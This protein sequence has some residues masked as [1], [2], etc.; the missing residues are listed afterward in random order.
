MRLIFC[1]GSTTRQLQIERLKVR[2]CGLVSRNCLPVEHRTR[3]EVV[4]TAE[5]RP[6]ARGRSRR[7][8][9]TG[10]TEL[11][12]VSQKR[13]R[14]RA[15]ASKLGR[16]RRPQYLHQKSRS[17][18]PIE[19]TT[20]SHQQANLS[21]SH[22]HL[23]R[24]AKGGEINDDN[25][26][27]KGHHPNPPT[28]TPPPPMQRQRIPAMRATKKTKAAPLK[29]ESCR[30]SY[31]SLPM[32]S[33]INFASF[34]KAIFSSHFSFAHR[35]TSYACPTGTKSHRRCGSTWSICTCRLSA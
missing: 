14:N 34:D 22:M 13:G 5:I 31:P 21:T 3:I 9:L 12:I 29:S 11:L 17:S 24:D 23:C 19:S 8:S 15:Q 25:E 7:S 32:K 33:P 2:V 16:S 18:T 26:S 27:R 35:F 6:P 4:A 20:S 30:H 1:I 10:K 28:Q